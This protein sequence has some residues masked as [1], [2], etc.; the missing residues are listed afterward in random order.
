[1]GR[2]NSHIANIAESSDP[3]PIYQ[4]TR[5][6]NWLRLPEYENVETDVAYFLVLISKTSPTQLAFASRYGGTK[7]IDFGHCEDG[8]F[9]TDYPQY[10]FDVPSDNTTRN[11]SYALKYEDFPLYRNENFAQVVVRLQGTDTWERL[12]FSGYNDRVNRNIVDMINNIRCLRTGVNASAFVGVGSTAHCSDI[13]YAYNLVDSKTPLTCGVYIDSVTEYYTSAISSSNGYAST[14]TKSLMGK[15]FKINNVNYNFR[16]C[17]SLEELI[18]DISEVTNFSTPFPLLN[19]GKALFINY[20][21]VTEFFS[22]SF[23][24]NNMTADALEAFFKTLPTVTTAC[25]LTCSG[26]LGYSDLTAEQIAIATA[27]NWTL[28]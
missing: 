5:P 24:T 23:G 12:Y 2:V 26:C 19:L 20:E 3:R 8:A 7:S 17:N 21:N 28:A 18:Y 11:W 13:I 16:G 15:P 27:R 22:F 1:M 9:V 6:A 25:T 14:D 4:G 10:T